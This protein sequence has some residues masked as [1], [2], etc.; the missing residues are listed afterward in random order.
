MQRVAVGLTFNR[1]TLISS[2]HS[3]HSPNSPLSIRRKAPS[4]WRSSCWPRRASSRVIACCCMASMRDK[5]PI[6]VWSSS[7]GWLPSCESSRN[8]SSSDFRSSS[9]WRI[10]AISGDFINQSIDHKAACIKWFW[11][12]GGYVPEGI[13][14]GKRLIF[15]SHVV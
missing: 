12:L 10:V 11:W 9:N 13:L 7:T 2:P 3:P 15:P 14:P 1:P 8:L 4:I 5:R 6:R